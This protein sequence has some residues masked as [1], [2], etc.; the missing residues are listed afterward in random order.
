MWLQREITLKPRSRGFHL[1]TAEVV[2]QIPELETL[3]VGLMHLLLQHTSASLTLN[4]NADPSV[5]IDFEGHF[6]RVVPENEPWYRHR[7]EGP[8]DLPAH[9]KSSLL[10]AT[11]TLPVGGGRLRLGTWQGIYLC[12]HRDYGGSRRLVVTLQGQPAPI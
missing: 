11:L 6:N 9:I 3:E 10:G 2:A 4:E 1:V 7:D 8:D 5:R 12:E